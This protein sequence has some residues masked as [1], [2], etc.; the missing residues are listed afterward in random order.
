MERDVQSDAFSFERTAKM[1]G[2]GLVATDRHIRSTLKYVSQKVRV[3]RMENLFRGTCP[4]RPAN[5]F[6][7]SAPPRTRGISNC[8]RTSTLTWSSRPPSSKNSGIECNLGR[9][10]KIHANK[11]LRFPFNFYTEAIRLSPYSRPLLEY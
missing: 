10:E 11:L 7:S 8:S 9:I 6:R 4:D 3:A 2:L 5:I 1:L